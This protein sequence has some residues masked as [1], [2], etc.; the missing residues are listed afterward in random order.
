MYFTYI[1]EENVVLLGALGIN[2]ILGGGFR[3]RKVGSMEHT[4]TLA[5]QNASESELNARVVEGISHLYS[6]AI[7]GLWPSP[8]LTSL[9]GQGG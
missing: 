4:L 1:P 8:L 3:R 5:F 2:S 9:G 7:V 6:L